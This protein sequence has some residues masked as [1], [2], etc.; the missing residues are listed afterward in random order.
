M[1][2]GLR[3][4]EQNS[5]TLSLSTTALPL[6]APFQHRRFLR[7]FDQFFSKEIAFGHNIVFSSVCVC[8]EE[9]SLIVLIYL[10]AVQQMKKK[11][12]KEKRAAK[13]NAIGST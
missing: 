12:E 8:S 6:M 3:T 11:K 9:E 1:T 13:K 5:N 2:I 4:F 7:Y 10:V